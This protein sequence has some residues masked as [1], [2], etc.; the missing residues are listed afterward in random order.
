MP[1]EMHINRDINFEMEA[2]FDDENS[3][4]GSRNGYSI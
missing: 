3:Y 2:T 1:H 4:D